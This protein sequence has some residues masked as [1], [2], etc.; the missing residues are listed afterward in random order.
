[1]LPSLGSHDIVAAWIVS[2]GPSTAPMHVSV[3][4]YT[5]HRNPYISNPKAPDISKYR[6]LPSQNSLTLSHLS[7]MAKNVLV[8]GGNAGIGRAACKLLAAEDGCRVFM[9][10]RSIERVRKA[11]P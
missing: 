11:M 3:L 4:R 7:T 2:L 6:H 5:A 10:S 8:T 9:G 1:M